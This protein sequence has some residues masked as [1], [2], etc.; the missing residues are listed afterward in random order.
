MA[1]VELEFVDHVADRHERRAAVVPGR[2]PHP[3][4]DR[5][6]EECH[7]A[8]MQCLA[9]LHDEV[10]DARR[11][12]VIDDPPVGEDRR[13]KGRPVQEHEV[14]GLLVSAMPMLHRVHA[15][16]DR[17][18]HTDPALGVRRDRHLSLVGLLHGR[19]HLLDRELR[20]PG[21][22]PG[23]HHPAGGHELDG[24]GTGTEVLAGRATD[25]VGA[26]GLPPH[27][28]AMATG[29]RHDTATGQHP[30]A[31]DLAVRDHPGK[32]DIDAVGAA[33]IA[34]GRD[35][36]TEGCLQTSDA[37]QDRLGTVLAA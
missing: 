10:R 32:L 28:P 20:L 34:D 14:D 23:G 21:L 19:G 4:A 6:L 30:G 9:L 2:D 18:E 29:H 17:V 11:D 7:E 35:A 3:G 37:A 8:L 5:R 31:D 15:G 36:G 24:V 12:A 25:R 26:V 33:D 22:A 16:K 27:P 1:D 13:H